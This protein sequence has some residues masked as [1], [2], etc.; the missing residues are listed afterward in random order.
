M[1]RWIVLISCGAALF[2][3][4]AGFY[5]WHREEFRAARELAK[6]EE[7]AYFGQNVVIPRFE[8]NEA[9]F[10]QALA[11][12]RR[13]A[14]AAGFP[15]RIPIRIMSERELANLIRERVGVT[16]SSGTTSEAPGQTVEPRELER[17]TP[18]TISLTNIPVLEAIRYI[19]ALGDR[20]FRIT[21]TAIEIT[22]WMPGRTM[23]PVLVRH[24]WRVRPG[25][26]LSTDSLATSLSA[27]KTKVD[28]APFLKSLGLSFPE[29]SSAHYD[30]KKGM[31]VMVNTQENWDLIDTMGCSGGEAPWFEKVAYRIR[32]FFHS[33]PSP[34]PAPPPIVTG[35]ANEKGESTTPAIPGL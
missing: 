21:E 23:P 5:L 33:Q 30:S 34:P 26:V 3:S 20:H 22:P 32:S 19:S 15:S 17:E 13:Q 10:E 7:V 2:G 12:V 24:E 8:L 35:I 1:K 11:Q 28:A 18:I 4:L 29:G 9:S 27:D 6:R 31:L 25:F 14:V 16:S